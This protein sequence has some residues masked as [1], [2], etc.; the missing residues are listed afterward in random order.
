MSQILGALAALP[1]LIKFLRDVFGFVKSIFGDNPK[2]FMQDAGVIFAKLG[3]IDEAKVGKEEAT[4]ARIEAAR[5][6][7]KLISRL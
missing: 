2:K 5:E 1:E 6:I 4:K 7:G 3:E